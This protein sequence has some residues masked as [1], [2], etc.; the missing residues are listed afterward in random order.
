MFLSGDQLRKGAALN[1]MQIAET[2][3]ERGWLKSRMAA[4]V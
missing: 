4:T 1:A 3:V 2:L